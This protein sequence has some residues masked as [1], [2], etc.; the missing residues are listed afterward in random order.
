MLIKKTVLGSY[1]ENAYIIINEETREAI[2]IDPGDEGKSRVRRAVKHIKHGAARFRR[3]G[4][5]HE[6]R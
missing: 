3:A 1:Q 2:F 4:R 6:D 5:R